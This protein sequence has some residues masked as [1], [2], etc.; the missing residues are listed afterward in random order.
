MEEYI[1]DRDILENILDF[2]CLEC[3]CTVVVSSKEHHKNFE[4]IFKFTK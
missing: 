2:S 1:T 3:N 4:L